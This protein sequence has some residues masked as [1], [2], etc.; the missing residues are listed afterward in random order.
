MNETVSADS[1]GLSET[2]AK[3]LY[4]FYVDQHYT[5]RDAI[6]KARKSTGESIKEP[7][8]GRYIRANGWTRSQRYYAKRSRFAQLND[9]NFAETRA[10]REGRI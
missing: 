10:K 6:R 2:V 7:M 8:A 3:A 4:E 9:A 5:L 1:F